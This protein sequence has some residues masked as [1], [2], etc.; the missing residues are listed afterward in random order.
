MNRDEIRQHLF[1]YLKQSLRLNART[2]VSTRV[3]AVVLS[4]SCA[5]CAGG[6]LKIVENRSSTKGAFLTIA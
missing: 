5:I 4:A 3:P 2:G 6:P 1:E